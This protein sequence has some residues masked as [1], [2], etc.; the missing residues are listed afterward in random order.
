MQYA[1]LPELCCQMLPKYN[2]WSDRTGID[3]GSG[4][5]GSL[6]FTTAQQ[7]LVLSFN[8][9]VL[10][11]TTKTREAAGYFWFAGWCHGLKKL[12][13]LFWKLFRNRVGQHSYGHM[14]C[15]CACVLSTCSSMNSHPRIT[16]CSTYIYIYIHC[17]CQPAQLQTSSATSATNQPSYNQTLLP[18]NSVTNQPSYQPD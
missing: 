7:D 14:A 15:V 3:F 6:V 5:G 9:W 10:V 13:E 12:L 16:C 4:T 17:S 8:A 2:V 1:H 18:N 11:L